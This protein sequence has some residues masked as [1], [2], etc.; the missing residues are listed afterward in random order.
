SPDIIAAIIMAIAIAIDFNRSR[1]LR[2][3]AVKWN[4]RAL[5]ADAYH[6][7]SDMAISASVIVLMIIGII[8]ERLSIALFD[9]WGTILDALVSFGIV[10][11]FSIIGIRLLRTA[12]DELMDRASEDLIRRVSSAVMSVPGVTSVRNIRARRAGYLAHIEVTIGVSDHLSISE[13]HGI[14]DKV[15]SAIK[16][17]IGPSLIM[18]HVEPELREKVEKA[19]AMVNDPILINI[20][21][22]DII[23][24][25]ESG[26]IVSLH[27]VVRSDV[28][29]DSIRDV[30]NK[31]ERSIKNAVPNAKVWIHI[32]PDKRHIDVDAV[33]RV[34]RE[35]VSKYGGY[36]GDVYLVTTNNI[37]IMRVLVYLPPNIDV[38]TAHNIATE[39]ENEIAKVYSMPHH[40]IVSVLPA[41]K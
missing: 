3:A 12:I 4:S 32:E 1:A 23:N 7:M 33:K 38:I 31:I 30:V 15:E 41:S 10:I 39:I 6:F 24:T 9:T 18:V 28:Q 25:P 2:N 26:I 14:A 11:Y 19:L 22:L 27:A 21:E 13:A 5:E 35:I 40:I 36:I 20:H 34:T 37:S 8:M 16:R 17:E 29:L